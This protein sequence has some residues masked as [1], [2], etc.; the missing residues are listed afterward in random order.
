MM[1]RLGDADRFFATG[2]PLGECSQLHEG[3]A[4]VGHGGNRGQG[5]KTEAL[6]TQLALPARSRS[7]KYSAPLIGAQGE[8]DPTEGI[9][10]RDL[11]AK[12]AEMVSKRQK[13]LAGLEGS[14]LIT[15]LP[16]S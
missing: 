13:P 6:A 9:I 11:K 1:D 2:Y 7:S 16:K 14:L 12:I 4:S 10:R 5:G 8:V 15:H 3:F